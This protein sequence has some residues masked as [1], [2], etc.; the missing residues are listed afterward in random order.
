MRRYDVD[1]LEVDTVLLTHLHGDH[2]GGVPFLILDG[3]LVSNRREPLTI[4]GPP[5]TEHRVRAAMDSL[6]AGSSP[7]EL[8]FPVRFLEYTAGEAL[9]AGDRIITAYPAAHSAG[10]NPHAV[11]VEAGGRT[12]AFSGDSAW[13]PSLVEASRSADLFICEAYTF[14]TGLPNHMDY[15]T[16]LEHRDEL[17]CRRI[18][19]TH[20]GSEMLDRLDQVEMETARDGM[21]VILD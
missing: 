16:L 1:P 14:D 9:S 15:T 5:D 3:R 19:L 2:F 17:E 6:F 11:R 21:A 10:A 13:T 20:M 4:I 12:I 7:D 8:P 18:I